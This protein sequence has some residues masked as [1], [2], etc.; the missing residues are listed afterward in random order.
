MSAQGI[1]GALDAY[2]EARAKLEKELTAPVILS[3]SD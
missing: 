2:S 1:R 3:G